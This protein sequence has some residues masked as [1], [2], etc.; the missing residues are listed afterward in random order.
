MKTTLSHSNNTSQNK[1]ATFVQGLTLCFL[2]SWLLASCSTTNIP[3]GDQ[4]FIGLK[5]IE[6]RNA[7]STIYKKHFA[8]TQEEI[9][10]ALATAPNGALLGSS[11]YRSPFP[12]SLWIY[13][14]F[15]GS[16][17]KIKQWLSKTFGNPPVLMSKVNPALRASVAKTVLRNNG[18]IHGDVYY[19]VL[20]R[21]NPKQAKIA[22]TVIPDTLFLIDSMSYN[23]FPA[24]MK[25]LIDSTRYESYIE[26]NTP[27]AV[28]QIDAERTRITQ[29]FRNNGYYYY[30]NSYASYL[31]DTFEIPNKALLRLQM[32]DSLSGDAL[33]KWYIGKMQITMRRTAYDQPTDSI[34][35]NFL[36]VYYSGKRSPIRP[37]IILRDLELRPRGLYNYDKHMASMQNINSVGL[38]SSTDFRFTPRAGTDTLDLMLTCTFD[39]PYDFYIEGNLKNRTIGRMGPELKVG[40]TRRNAFRGGEKLDINLHGSYEWQTN[41]NHMDSYTYGADASVEFPR[42]IAPFV[43]NRLV[44]RLKN[45]RIRRRKPY[46]ATPWTKAKV[47]TDIIRRPGY[48]KMHIVSG[49]WGYRWQN[50]E[51]N[52]HQFTPL[53]VKYQYKNSFTEE[54]L[55]VLAEHPYLQTTMDDYLIPKMEYTYT[56]VS[57]KNDRYPFKWETTLQESGN[58]TSLYFLARGH[59]WNEKGKELFKTRY[60]QFLKFETDYTKS[61]PV[62][63]NG[64]LVIHGSLGYIWTYGNSSDY[65]FTEGFYTGGANSVRAFPARSIGPGAFPGLNN[66]QYSYLYQ[67][68]NLKLLVNLE[69]RHRLFGNLH[70]AIFFDAGN[71]WSTR[72]YTIPVTDDMDETDRVFAQANNKTASNIDFKFSNLPRQ[73]ATG[74]GIGLRYDLEFLVLRV[75]WGFGLH[76]P[77][78]TSKSGYFNIERF[79]DMHT[80]HIA[81]G[82]PF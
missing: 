75:D 66:N 82:Y 34:S 57:K 43:N 33:K 32:A 22:Y 60:S 6:Y 25:Q 56:Y 62:L 20:T 78:N 27:F 2:L 68:G 55:N 49:E 50:T 37:G 15:N 69:F 77:Y 23:G 14:A 46:Y 18:Y 8:N 61:W 59:G 74:T 13:N 41:G 11:Y 65:P 16:K 53:T 19:E 63:T 52:I 31:A 40:V 24:D 35:R 64:R 26:K 44:K 71:V 47:S 72:D 73:L 7:D 1:R 4:L 28:S 45:G 30:N 39:K 42:I 54:F 29:L 5:K 21:K 67:H 70:G 10:A 81:I 3:E 79:S 9:E 58:I 80:L 36:K 38:F 12:Y 76:V 17:N 48:Y 51:K